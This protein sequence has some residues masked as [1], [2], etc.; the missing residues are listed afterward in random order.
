MFLDTAMDAS[1]DL[2]MFSLLFFKG[3]HFF[4]LKL[5]K[6]TTLKLSNDDNSD[7]EQIK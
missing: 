5:E 3:T 6:C 4:R 7:D 1:L 2:L